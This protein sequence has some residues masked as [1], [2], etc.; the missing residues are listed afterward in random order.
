M[1]KI[2]TKYRTIN[3]EIEGVLVDVEYNYTPAESEV[4]Y[5]ADGSGH[6]GCGAKLDIYDI[7]IKGVDIVPLVSDYIY[8]EIENQIYKLHED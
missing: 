7:K 4:T 3:L 2:K 1:R 5:Y 6:P 8:D